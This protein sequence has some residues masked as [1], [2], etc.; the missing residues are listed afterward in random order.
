MNLGHN[1]DKTTLLADDFHFIE[2]DT[3]IP[4]L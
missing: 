1:L 4:V 3:K 2:L